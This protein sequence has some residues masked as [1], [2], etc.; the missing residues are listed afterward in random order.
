VAEYLFGQYGALK[1]SLEKTRQMYLN[2][3]GGISEEDLL[4]KE[5]AIL[6]AELTKAAFFLLPRE[7]TVERGNR[8]DTVYFRLVATE[9]VSV[10][11]Y[12]PSQPPVGSRPIGVAGNKE[13]VFEFSSAGRDPEQMKEDAKENIEKMHS[14][15]DALAQEVDAAREQLVLD[16]TAAVAERRDAVRHTRDMLEALGGS[17]D[18][19]LVTFRPRR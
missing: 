16:V 19:K 9:D 11:N 6:A 7:Y 10:L 18:P 1:D 14:W 5:P 3:V 4:T 8:Y 2:R 15:C 12:R 17:P 13:I